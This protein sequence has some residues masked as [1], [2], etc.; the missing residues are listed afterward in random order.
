MEEMTEKKVPPHHW[1][2]PQRCFTGGA[3]EPWN[4]MGEE[5]GKD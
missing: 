3:A 2:N 4:S 1:D 5:V